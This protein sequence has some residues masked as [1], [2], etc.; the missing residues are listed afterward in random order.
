MDNM[1]R[2]IERRAM[3]KW[4]KKNNLLIRGSPR[5]S[6]SARSSDWYGMSGA[7]DRFEYKDMIDDWWRDMLP[8]REE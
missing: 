2:D 6:Y 5:L 7:L 1:I 8:P 4:S 3:K